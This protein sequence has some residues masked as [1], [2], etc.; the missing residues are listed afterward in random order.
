MERHIRTAGKY[1][2]RAPYQASAAI[3]TMTLA[4]FVATVLSI[5]AYASE[6]TLNYFETRPQIIAFLE[7][8]ATPEQVSSLQRTLE[9]DSRVKDLHYVSKEQALGIYQEATRDNPLLSELV[10]PKVF[11]ASLEFSVT[12]LSYAEDLVGQLEK[13]GIVDQVVFTASLGDSG[14]LGEVIA[15]LRRITGYIRVGGVVVLGF[16]LLS[17]LL[18]LLVIISM[19]IS[20][21][22]KEIEILKLLGATSGF[23]RMPFVLEGLFYTTFGAFMGWLLASLLVLY[24]VP[25]LTSYFGEIPV[26]PLETTSLLG[27]LGTIL[28]GELLLA[29]VLGS[30]GSMFAVR[31]YLKI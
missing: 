19:R 1:I 28:G 21:R 14:S 17:S 18:I 23:I 4:F 25:A 13:E 2:R 30:L 20:M 24:S 31:R 3:L 16:L 11:P 5:L 6:S 27:L 15:N 10:S 7:D 12:D 9:S 29:L 26:L 8:E 22:R